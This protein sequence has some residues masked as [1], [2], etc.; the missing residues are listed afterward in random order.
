MRTKILASF[1]IY[2]LTVGVLCVWWWGNNLI[3]LFNI[4]GVVLGDKVY[5]LAIDRLGDISSPY[6]HYTIPWVFRVPQIYVP[7]SIVLWGLVGLSL[8]LVYNRVRK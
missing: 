2:G 7:V 1:L 3:L 8:Q 4:P 5:S 6:A